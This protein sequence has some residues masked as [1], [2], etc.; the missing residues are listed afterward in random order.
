MNACV[1]VFL[2]FFPL[3]VAFFLIVNT[4]LYILNVLR[5]RLAAEP[6]LRLNLVKICCYLD[7]I[8]LGNQL[9]APKVFLRFSQ[10]REH[11]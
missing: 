3:M 9:S 11:F 5:Q 10:K 4:N 1:L 2:C 8:T 7:L 6:T